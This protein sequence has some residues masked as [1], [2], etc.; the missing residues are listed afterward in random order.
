MM[1]SKKD[2]GK[3]ESENKKILEKLSVKAQQQYLDQRDIEYKSLVEKSDERNRI[4]LN[5]SKTSELLNY[6]IAEV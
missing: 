6:S 3:I 5:G 2:L 4:I 1:K